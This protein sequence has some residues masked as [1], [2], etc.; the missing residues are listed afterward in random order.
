MF[1]FHA[2]IVL[3]GNIN[4]YVIN[5]LKCIF[6]GNNVEDILLIGNNVSFIDR[7]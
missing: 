6:I 1:I 7:V 4:T 3:I 5:K 2:R